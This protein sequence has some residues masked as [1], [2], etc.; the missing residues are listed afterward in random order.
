[1]DSGLAIRLTFRLAFG[2]VSLEPLGLFM[3]LTIIQPL[4]EETTIPSLLSDLRRSDLQLDLLSDLL[5]QLQPV[6]TRVAVTKK[7][8][9]LSWASERWTRY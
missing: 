6:V 7:A 5:Y 9:C 1:M 4:R 8:R 2:H 3:I